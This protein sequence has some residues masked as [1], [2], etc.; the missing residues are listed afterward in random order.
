MRVF[1][2]RFDEKRV[3]DLPEILTVL[4][5]LDRA[6]LHRH[7][8]YAVPIRRGCDEKPGLHVPCEAHALLM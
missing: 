6:G 5:P 4:P 7:D 1:L 3:L 8:E 2:R